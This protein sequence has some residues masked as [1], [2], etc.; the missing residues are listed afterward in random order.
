MNAP[1]RPRL[2][3]PLCAAVFLVCLVANAA[4][5]GLHLERSRLVNIKRIASSRS[6]R[7]EWRTLLTYLRTGPTFKVRL[8]SA[9][10]LM[11][12]SNEQLKDALVKIASGRDGKG[13][14]RQAAV[15]ALRG[16][17]RLMTDED[18]EKILSSD[19]G[20]RAVFVDTLTD[21]ASR[22]DLSLKQ[23]QAILDRYDKGASNVRGNRNVGIVLFAGTHLKSHKGEP[24][25]EEIR[26]VLEQFFIDCARKAGSEP[27]NLRPFIG[28]KMA[29][30]GVPGAVEVLIESLTD[31]LHHQEG[32]AG[33]YHPA[34]LLESLRRFTGTSMGY[35]EK[36]MKPGDPEAVQAIARWFAWWRENK[37][38]AE[39]R[40][41][42]VK[43]SARRA[44][45]TSKE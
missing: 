8:R 12:V 10:L 35:D 16:S 22:A 3:I 34:F 1:V 36:K 26:P 6:A 20:M 25:D 27:P 31:H 41:P 11:R 14:A 44:S 19:E 4:T 29:E 9:N 5:S 42:P 7:K 43:E 21:L 30:N 28:L 15:R 38:K 39:Y 18:V 24:F 13:G 17:A 40:L 37:D 45:S 23:V 2:P 32:A 33:L